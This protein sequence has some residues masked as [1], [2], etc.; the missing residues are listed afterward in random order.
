[1]KLW[2]IPLLILLYLLFRQRSNIPALIGK[3]AYAQR[4]YPKALKWFTR[5]YK[6]GAM[7]LSNQIQ[8]GYIYL[9]CGDLQNAKTILEPCIAKTQRGSA[10]RNQVK[11]LMALIEWKE[12]DLTEA[13]DILEDVM[14]DGFE[15]SVVYENLGIFY[16]LSDAKEKAL[17]FNQKAYEYNSDSHIICDNL[18]ESYARL[19]QNEKSEELYKALIEKEPRFPEAYYGYGELLLTLGRKDEAVA[20]I[21]TSLEKPFFFLNTHPKEYVEE[22][23]EKAKNA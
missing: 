16:N 5:A 12:G 21:E 14:Y 11:N 3:F 20:M 13:I 23:L 10:P 19:G 17:A 7:T 2:M 1:M 6:L 15:T 18:A 9:R 4:D 8:L 22:L